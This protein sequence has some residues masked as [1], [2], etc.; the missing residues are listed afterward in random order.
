MPLSTQQRAEYLDAL[1][2]H[3]GEKAFH[4]GLEVLQAADSGKPLPKPKV[5]KGAKPHPMAE[6]L[7]SMSSGA[8]KFP[9]GTV[10][11]TGFCALQC[12]LT[13]NPKKDPFGFAACVF[14]CQQNSSGGGGSK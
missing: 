9:T 8:K 1:R 10:V 11:N 14:Q 3:G 7:A 6:Q 12:A 13:H 4:A 5:A 2:A